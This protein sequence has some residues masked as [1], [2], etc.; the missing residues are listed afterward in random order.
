MKIDLLKVCF[1]ALTV[2]EVS[3]AA[4]TEPTTLTAVRTVEAEDIVALTVPIIRTVV[5]TVEKVLQNI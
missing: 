1:S 4:K 3:I 5:T 2:V